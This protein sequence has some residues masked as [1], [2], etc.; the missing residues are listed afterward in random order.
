MPLSNQ[1]LHDLIARRAERRKA[2]QLEARTG[3]Q[4]PPLL[5]LARIKD[6]LNQPGWPSKAD[7]DAE[8]ARSRER[9]LRKARGQT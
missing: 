8:I 4:L 9:R 1:Q 3:E 7:I 5:E 2:V 6:S